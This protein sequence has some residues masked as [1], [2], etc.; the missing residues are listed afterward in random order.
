MKKQIFTILTLVK[1]IKKALHAYNM[2]ID[3]Q[4]SAFNIYYLYKKNKLCEAT[5]AIFNF[6]LIKTIM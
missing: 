6:S 2:K 3:N 1:I 4:E 5:N